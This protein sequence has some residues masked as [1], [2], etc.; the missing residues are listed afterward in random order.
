[1][2]SSCCAS[3][4]FICS[5]SSSFLS[6]HA[7]SHFVWRASVPDGRHM[8]LLLFPGSPL[9]RN[10]EAAFLY[11]TTPHP[12]PTSASLSLSQ[13]LAVYPRL[14]WNARSS[15]LGL[16]CPGITGLHP[17]HLLSSG[18]P[19]QSPLQSLCHPSPLSSLSPRQCPPPG[20]LTVLSISRFLHRILLVVFFFQSVGDLEVCKGARLARRGSWE[21]GGCQAGQ[22]CEFAFNSLL[23]LTL[24]FSSASSSSLYRSC[25]PQTWEATSPASTCKY[26]MWICGCHSHFRP[27]GLHSGSQAGQSLNFAG[28]LT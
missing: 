12:C 15:Y 14:P 1:M 5:P 26:V 24:C 8:L 2:L 16:A 17:H 25:S 10:A 13:D 21:G 28:R 20:L 7:A 6:T 27:H 18:S 9:I 22:R 4:A 3:F 19:V 11:S 23:R